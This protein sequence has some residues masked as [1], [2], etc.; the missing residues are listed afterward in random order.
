MNDHH[1]TRIGDRYQHE[2]G[3]YHQLL[4][5][6]SLTVTPG[7][8]ELGGCITAG[9][10]TDPMTSADDQWCTVVIQLMNQKVEC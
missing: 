7:G 6:G 9:G 1:V 2:W 4:A 10:A 5:T 3:T 8:D